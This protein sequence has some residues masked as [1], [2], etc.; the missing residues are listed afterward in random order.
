MLH[1]SYTRGLY[2]RM[3]VPQARSR[4]MRRSRPNMQ[5]HA[6]NHAQRRSRQKRHGQLPCHDLYLTRAELTSLCFTV[7]CE[8]FA[9]VLEPVAM[10]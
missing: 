6:H 3:I 9:D 8:Q 1:S 5:E 2:L 4:Q 10:R 7:L